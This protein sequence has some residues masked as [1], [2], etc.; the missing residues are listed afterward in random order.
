MDIVTLILFTTYRIQVVDSVTV[1]LMA[2]WAYWI[3]YRLETGERVPAGLC[4]PVS[5]LHPTAA[6][7]HVAPFPV[8]RFSCCLIRLIETG[9][10]GIVR[11]FHPDTRRECSGQTGDW[12]LG[13][14]F[15]GF[16]HTSGANVGLKPA[17][18]DS[19]LRS[20]VSPL[21]A[22]R[23][24]GQ[25][26]NRDLVF[27]ILPIIPII[28]IIQTFECSFFLSLYFSNQVAISKLTNFTVIFWDFPPL[29]S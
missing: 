10:R 24:D 20:P 17:T 7:N 16:S 9:D 29:L 18:D 22:A 3:E 8:A 4:S 5:R 15:A 12:W 11:Q 19:A 26:K 21:K 28:P 23:A 14:T 27:R 25:F 2:L 13:A 6:T 1:W